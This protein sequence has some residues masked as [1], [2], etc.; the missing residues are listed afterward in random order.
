MNIMN[1]FFGIQ[2]QKIK[3]SLEIPMFQ[4]HGNFLTDAVLFKLK[5][6]NSKWEIEKIDENKTNKHFFI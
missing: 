3:S 2:N 1:F 5:I 6:L 4:N